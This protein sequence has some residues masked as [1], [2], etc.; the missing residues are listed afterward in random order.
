MPNTRV[1]PLE[2]EA[3]HR[4][5]AEGQLT[6][7]C[8][9]RR[10]STANTQP[11]FNPVSGRTTYTTPTTFASDVPCRLQSLIGGPGQ[12]TV[13]VGERQVA[14]HRYSLSVPWDTAEAVF[15]DEV[16][17]T[18]CDGDPVLVG[19]VFRVL[20]QRHGSLS[21]YRTYVVEEIQPAAR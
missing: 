19:R 9:L 18:R 11:T 15:G 20:D 6:S 8:D 10:S 2:W 21:W 5:A 13:D 7:T 14:T 16:V 4:N 17:V 12:Q 3:H 1:V